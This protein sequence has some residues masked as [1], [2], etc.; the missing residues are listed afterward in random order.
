M[1]RTALL[2]RE[3]RSSAFATGS[4]LEYRTT[5]TPSY[6]ALC[7]LGFALL[8]AAP[9]FGGLAYFFLPIALATMA[10]GVVGLLRCGVVRI[11][12]EAGKVEKI[13]GLSADSWA[14]DE[15]RAVVPERGWL[16][17]FAGWRL[18]LELRIGERF[19]LL[20]GSREE[21]E[22]ARSHLAGQL[23][24]AGVAGL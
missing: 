3:R 11:D 12:I 4:L 18:Q 17:G 14:V 5:P 23:S 20:F 21:V 1:T 8:V 16:P 22:S 10:E 6:G 15:I 19:W 9:F 13:G 2:H 24:A 7:V